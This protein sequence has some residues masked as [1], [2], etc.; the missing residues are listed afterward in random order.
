[1]LN[2]YMRQL[3][4]PQIGESGQARLSAGRILIIGCGALGSMQAQALTRAGVG[5]M[6]IVDRDK[7]EITNLHRQILYNERDAATGLFKADIAAKKLAYINSGVTIEPH[8]IE[9]NAEN[10]DG[11]INGVDIVLDGCDNAGTRIIVNAACVRRGIP[12]IY[13]GISRTEGLAMAISPGNGPCLRCLFPEM[14]EPGT[15]QDT[16]QGIL[17]TAP[18]IIGALQATLALRFL[19]GAPDAWGHLFR[20]DLWRMRLAQMKVARR[21]TCPACGHAGPAT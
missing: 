14:P 15:L 21:E 11:F 6:R 9:V 2:R 5:F 19:L 20:L 16:P 18:A 4:L 3:M 12:W 17:P 1:M 10:I 13:G 8:G 7:V